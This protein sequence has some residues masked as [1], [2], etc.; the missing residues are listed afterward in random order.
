MVNRHIKRCSTSLINRKMQIKIKMRQ[1]LIYARM[2]IIK[3]TTNSKC[4]QGYG[5]E[6]TLVQCYCSVSKSCPTLCDPHGLQHASF[7]CFSLSAGACSNSCL[8]SWWCHPTS[9]CSVFHFSSC[10]QSFPTSGPFPASW[11][12]I[13]GGQSIGASAS[14][15]PMNIQG[16]F[17]LRLTGLVSLLCK[18]LS[19]VFS[20]T[21]V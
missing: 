8:L 14:V 15:F 7:P 11:L 18:E 4:Y 13:S 20:N 12:F 21:T 5:E 9:S 1:H 10:P 6:G 16:W 17:P 19:R 2:V 3:K